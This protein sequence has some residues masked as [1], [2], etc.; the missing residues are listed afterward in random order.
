MQPFPFPIMHNRNTNQKHRRSSAVVVTIYSM[1]PDT[2]PLDCR[3]ITPGR[4]QLRWPKKFC[5]RIRSADEKFSSCNNLEALE[6]IILDRV[7]L[8]LRET[9]GPMVRP[10]LLFWTEWLMIC[11]GNKQ[12]REGDMYHLAVF[13]YLSRYSRVAPFH[14]LLK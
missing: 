1:T 9:Q 7:L 2:T 13:A 4:L 8:L 3:V 10:C 6:Y 5:M 11:S 14:K 12:A